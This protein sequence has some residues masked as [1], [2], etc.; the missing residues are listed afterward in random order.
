MPLFGKNK[1]DKDTQNAQSS[2]S[3]SKKKKKSKGGSAQSGNQSSQPLHSSKHKKPHKSKHPPHSSK[4]PNLAT[5]SE[6]VPLKGS[7]DPHSIRFDLSDKRVDAQVT[8]TLK[9]LK[10]E[11]K[12]LEMDKI[13][14]HAHIM[15]YLVGRD[16]VDPKRLDAADL[17][18][19]MHKY[20]APLFVKDPRSRGMTAGTMNSQLDQQMYPDK[21]EDLHKDPKEKAKYIDQMSGSQSRRPKKD[22]RGKLHQGIR[23]QHPVD[24]KAAL[25]ELFIQANLSQKE[26]DTQLLEVQKLLSKGHRKVTAHKSD[27]KGWDRAYDK[28]QNKYRDASLIKDLVRGTLVF[29][30]VTDLVQGRDYIYQ[31]FTVYGT[32]NSIGHPTETGYQDMKIN[33]KLSTGHIGE[34]QL[35][36]QS[37]VESKHAGG[38]GLYRLIRD[39]DEGKTSNFNDDP[40]KA[41]DRLQPV[42]QTLRANKQK[43]IAN[44]QNKTGLSTTLGP[45]NPKTHDR[46]IAFVRW[47]IAS[48]DYG[49]SFNLNSEEGALL[50]EISKDVYASAEKGITKEIEA[51]A[52]LRT[53][54]GVG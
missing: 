43:A 17:A 2:Q 9:L 54:F 30:S 39:F 23:L 20:M 33:V 19:Q 34:L 4:H 31:C 11:F 49:Q 44:H 37:M 13:D 18:L 42:L 25:D 35:H 16:G 45:F 36:L 22:D 21:V 12:D 41:V 6:S 52:S 28:Q 10:K 50:K 46:K 14:L 47:L 48:I 15:K 38:H 27:I 32:K 51:S 8:H 3:Q 1:K 26:F 7:G 24:S 5:V 40:K 53:T 29:N